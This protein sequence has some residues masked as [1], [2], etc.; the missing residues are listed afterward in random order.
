MESPSQALFPAQPDNP[1]GEARKHLI[2]TLG[3]EAFA[4]DIAQTREITEYGSL[5][6]V[7]MVPKAIRGVINLR[8][9][10]VPVIDL[11]ARFGRGSTRVTRRTCIVILEL[12]LEGGDGLQTLGIVVDGVNEVLEI[13]AADIAP[14]PSF[15]A[16]L[17]TDFI[18]GMGRVGED[19]IVI[20]D[21][22]RVLSL[23]ALTHSLP[24]LI[25]P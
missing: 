9:A 10:V 1:P 4:I 24:D 22:P 25:R 3:V 11:A 8:G 6:E 15:G 17:R 13:P 21:L 7:P 19:F 16:G 20:L 2:F 12:E 5:T 18:A 23:G 14:A